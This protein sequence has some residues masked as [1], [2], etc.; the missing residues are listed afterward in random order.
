MLR[1]WN[2]D[3]DNHDQMLSL[4]IPLPDYLSLITD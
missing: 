2:E 4:D 1:D 3:N